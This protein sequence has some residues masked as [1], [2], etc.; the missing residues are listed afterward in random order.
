MSKDLLMYLSKKIQEEMGQIEND[1]PM[2]TAKDISDYKYACGVY[3]GL[4]VANNIL[5][6]AA[7]RL[8]SID[9]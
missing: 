4:M 2:G 9:E 7:E 6:E 3:R 1:L 8:E 5:A